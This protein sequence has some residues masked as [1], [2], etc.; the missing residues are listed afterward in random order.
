MESLKEGSR[1]MADLIEQCARD[2]FGNNE[3]L[4]LPLNKPGFLRQQLTQDPPQE[5]HSLDELLEVT[6]NIIYPG[7]MKWQSP[8]FF[9]YYTSSVNVTSVLA[10]MFAVITHSPGFSYAV[11][12]SYTELE[13][14]VVD[15]S[16]KAMGLPEKFLLKNSGG[17]ALNNSASESIFNSV[18]AAKFCKMKNLG[19]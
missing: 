11:S 7:T 8:R 12:P 19:I 16:A 4:V 10:D 3:G 18:H 13:N 5:G 17:G 14:I 1:K 2:T 6:K 9:G 15:W